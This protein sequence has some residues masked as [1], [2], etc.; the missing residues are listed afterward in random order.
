MKTFVTVMETLGVVVFVLFFGSAMM[1]THDAKAQKPETTQSM[2]KWRGYPLEVLEDH[3]RH[4][5]CYT[6][7]LGTNPTCVPDPEY[8]KASKK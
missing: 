3:K 8:I 5:I 4:V 7:T 1:K 6:F 2:I